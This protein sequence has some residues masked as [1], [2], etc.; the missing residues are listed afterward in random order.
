MKAVFVTLRF[1]E[2]EKKTWQDYSSLSPVAVLQRTVPIYTI[3]Q[4]ILRVITY[5]Y[6]LTK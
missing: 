2:I 5:S 6:N 4:W 1:L 3:W